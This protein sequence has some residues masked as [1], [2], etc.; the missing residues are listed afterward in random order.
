M[1]HEMLR[2]F[3]TFHLGIALSAIGSELVL[4]REVSKY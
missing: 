3:G 1:Y 4:W 2:A